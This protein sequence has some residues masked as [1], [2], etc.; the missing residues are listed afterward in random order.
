MSGY[1]SNI[2]SR[3]AG[4]CSM[5]SIRPRKSNFESSNVTSPFINNAPNETVSDVTDR[6]CNPTKRMEPVSRDA[7][8]PEKADVHLATSSDSLPTNSMTDPAVEDIVASEVVS[9]SKTSQ[10]STSEIRSKNLITISPEA[11]NRKGNN[12]SGPDLIGPSLAS[13]LTGKLE[14]YASTKNKLS[15]DAPVPGQNY[16]ESSS[17][18]PV[19][20]YVKEAQEIIKPASPS[21][22]EKTNISPVRQTIFSKVGSAIKRA[23]IQPETKQTVKVNIG[24]VEVRAAPT[25]Q[26]HTMPSP[27]QPVKS[28]FGDYLLVRNYEF[29]ER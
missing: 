6:F 17:L 24:K 28:G 29:S 5:N 15:T 16:H 18:L 26:S 21:K 9:N 27:Q 2:A 20:S 11:V 22:I 3:G 12:P 8:P 23:A 19:Q 14:N 10:L 25:Q 7:L 1:L 13:D 4:L